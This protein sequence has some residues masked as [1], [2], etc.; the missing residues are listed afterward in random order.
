MK[1]IKEFNYKILIESPGRVNLI[2]EHID[3]NGGNVLP[4]SI[5]KKIFL[6][7]KKNLK[8]S[9]CKVNSIHYNEIITFELNEEKKELNSNWKNYIFGVIHYLKKL[10]G[11]QLNGFECIIDSNLPL[12]SGISSSSALICG[13]IKGLNDLFKLK[14]S[15][16][17]MI[18]IS[19]K[20]EH[21]FI[22]V[23]GG[24]MDQF[25][26][27]F[28]KKDKIIL[29]NCDTLNLK[30]IDSKFSPYKFL[31][32]NTNVNHNLSSSDYNTRVKECESALKK[33]KIENK[34]LSCLANAPEDYII[35]N[36]P[37]FTKNEFKRALYVSQENQR[38]LKSSKLLKTSNFVDFGKL[39]YKSH[40]GLKNLY[41]VSCKELDFLV[42][43]SKKYNYV[44]GSRMMGGGFG[45]CTINLIKEDYIKSYIKIVSEK[46]LNKFKKKLTSIEVSIEDGIKTIKK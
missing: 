23:K 22:G 32:L 37:L 8:N 5:N 16:H 13:L 19:Q 25:A 6:Y 11:D 20:V 1:N 34:K 38:V 24:I 43:Y 44:L 35:K 41:E 42:D 2:G 39:M 46:Y 29:L 27:F 12:G 10:K 17:E 28:G 4:A 18:N 14:I 7:F 3:Y 33:I 45:G 36:E 30:M 21:N 15:N 31:L 9:I 40:E 26:I